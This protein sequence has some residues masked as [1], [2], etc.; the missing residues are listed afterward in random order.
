M[1]MCSCPGFDFWYCIRLL[2]LVVHEGS[3]VGVASSS[4][5]CL[6]QLRQ[7]LLQRSSTSIKAQMEHVDEESEARLIQVI[8]L[9]HSIFP[10]GDWELLH[11]HLLSGDWEYDTPHHTSTST[12][13]NQNSSTPISPLVTESSST[14]S[15]PTFH[16]LTGSSSTP[17]SPLVTESM[18]IPSFPGITI[19]C[20]HVITDQ[21]LI[22]HHWTA[23]LC[24]STANVY[25]FRSCWSTLYT[26]ASICMGQCF[27][28]INFYQCK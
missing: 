11:S 28:C 24:P 2:S 10:S 14:P 22:S 20:V 15:L 19:L 13:V 1:V 23:L 12:L 3:M 17:T 26:L 7:T 9:L 21:Y 4:G 5:M 27:L 18:V 16:F 8:Y 6:Q 25:P